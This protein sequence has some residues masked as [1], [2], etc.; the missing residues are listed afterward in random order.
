MKCA[1]FPTN[2]T[3]DIFFVHQ[4]TISDLWLKHH[5]IHGYP[6]CMLVDECYKISWVAYRHDFQRITNVRAY[7]VHSTLYLLESVHHWCASP[8]FFRGYKILIDQIHVLI[9]NI[10]CVHSWT[11]H[12][13]QSELIDTC[14]ALVPELERCYRWQLQLYGHFYVS[15]T[16]NSL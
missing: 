2:L 3:P 11:R 5:R 6:I 14:K 10:Y 4:K 13:S 8:F 1:H 12:L 15:I 9:S 16:N 7:H